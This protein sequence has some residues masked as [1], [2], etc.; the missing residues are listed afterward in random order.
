MVTAVDEMESAAAALAEKLGTAVEIASSKGAALRLLE[1]HSYAAVVLDQMLAESDAE[2]ADLIL[3]RAGLAVPVQISFALAGSAR[4]EREVRGALTRRR[5]E[6]ELAGAAAA[7]AMDADLKDAVTGLLLE[8]RLALAEENIPPRIEGR[9]Q[10]LAA[11][12]EEL[13]SRLNPTAPRREP[14]AAA[15]A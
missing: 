14:A 1:R 5:R 2:G 11:L 3:K 7:A 13:R 10:A 6:Q 12:A 4:L 8:S 15:R 9:L